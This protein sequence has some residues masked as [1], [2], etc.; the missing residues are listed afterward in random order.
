MPP[1]LHAERWL[2]HADDA[3]AD[4]PP[5]LSRNGT[6]PWQS[7]R[8]QPPGGSNSLLAEG[9]WFESSRGRQ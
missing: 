6:R 2:L 4:A 9:R 8:C 3:L 5:Q 1:G 7:S